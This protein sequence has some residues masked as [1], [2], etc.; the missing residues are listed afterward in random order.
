[1]NYVVTPLG[2]RQI[3]GMQKAAWTRMLTGK[4]VLMKHYESLQW[5]KSEA[6]R[7]CPYY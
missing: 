3:K 1:M 4:E 5:L 6:P 7:E 2:N